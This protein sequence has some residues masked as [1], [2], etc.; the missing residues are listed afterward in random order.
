M[1]NMKNM[2]YMIYIINF[3]KLMQYYLLYIF[4]LCVNSQNFKP[5]LELS[6]EV[7][8]EINP[9]FTRVFNNNEGF[10][11]F[12]LDKE[13][14]QEME[15]RLYILANNSD[16]SVYNPKHENKIF[17]ALRFVCN[18]L[19]ESHPLHF[20]Y[21]DEEKFIKNCITK[22]IYPLYT[23]DPLNTLAHLINQDVNIFL[24]SDKGD[25]VLIGSLTIYP[26]NWT[27]QERKNFT[28]GELHRK[29]PKWEENKGSGARLVFSDMFKTAGFCKYRTNMFVQCH[30]KLSITNLQEDLNSWAKDITIFDLFLRRELQF[31]MHVNNE[32]GIFTVET[33]IEPLSNMSLAELNFIYVY[34]KGLSPQYSEYHKFSLWGPILEKYIIELLAKHKKGKK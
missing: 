18:K 3:L 14:S 6:K 28:L 11:T 19:V 2:K 15:T 29:V 34:F 33:F 13:Y 5:K 24:K 7:F 4:G 21:I 27:P 25:P 8:K 12:N 32:V 22:K 26:V 20:I 30:D 10:I 17:L 31:F 16:L 1:K 23:G 9:V